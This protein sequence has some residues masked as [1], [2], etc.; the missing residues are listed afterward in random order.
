M[1]NHSD[2]FHS[3]ATVPASGQRFI[4]ISQ[5]PAALAKR[6]LQ[7]TSRQA[8]TIATERK[9]PFFKSPVGRDLVITE[10]LLDEALRASEVRAHREWRTQGM[11]ANVPRRS[12]RKGS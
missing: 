12:R 6:G 8:R 4:T 5:L 9:L 10:E 7:I 3:A 1:P 2:L 11:R